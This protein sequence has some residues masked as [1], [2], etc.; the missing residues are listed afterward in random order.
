VCCNYFAFV[1]FDLLFF[2]FV[3][4]NSESRLIVIVL[5]SECSKAPMPAIVS[6]DAFDIVNWNCHRFNKRV[7]GSADT[8]CKV[9][10]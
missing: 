8:G 1:F 6:E 2:V 10:E 5:A 4:R 3:G 9:S 7:L